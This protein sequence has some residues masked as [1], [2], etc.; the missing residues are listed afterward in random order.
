MRYSLKKELLILITSV[1]LILI[2]ILGIAYGKTISAY[3]KFKNLGA[4][5]VSI[6]YLHD[7][8]LSAEVNFMKDGKVFNIVFRRIKTENFFN[9]SVVYLESINGHGMLIY[10]CKHSSVGGNGMSNQR[11][12]ASFG[13]TNLIGIGQKGLFFELFEVEESS[14]A[15]IIRNIDTIER[16]FMKIPDDQYSYRR[17]GSG[18]ESFFKRQKFTEDFRRNFQRQIRRDVEMNPELFTFENPEC[19]KHY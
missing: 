2:P 5:V 10:S 7:E 12:Y 4:D 19:S 16:N 1:L 8:Y 18:T 15:W 6:G 3:F 13:M 9:P 14:I 11:S 17:F